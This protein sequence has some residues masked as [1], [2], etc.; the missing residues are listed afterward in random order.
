M[1]GKFAAAAVG[2][3]ELAE[4]GLNA[5]EWRVEQKSWL[6]SLIAGSSNPKGFVGNHVRVWRHHEAFVCIVFKTF[7][8]GKAAPN[9]P[10]QYHFAV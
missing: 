5:V 3:S 7:R 10:I 9:A 1:I 6:P 4:V 8:T 2:F